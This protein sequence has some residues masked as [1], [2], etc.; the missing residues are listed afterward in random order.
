MWLRLRELHDS[1]KGVLMLMLSCSNV[2]SITCIDAVHLRT[3]LYF[4]ITDF[5]QPQ[6]WQA[7]SSPSV[8]SWS[9]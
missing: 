8:H 7:L 1:Y 2:Y 9:V 6:H 5:D 3:E 4:A